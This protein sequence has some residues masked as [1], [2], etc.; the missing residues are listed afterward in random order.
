MIENTLRPIYQHYLVGPIAKRLLYGISPQPVTYLAGVTGI[1]VMPLLAFHFLG[2]ATF[3]LLLSGFLDTLDGTIARETDQVSTM[4]S[5]L[6]IMSDRIVEFAVILGLFAID[7][8]SRA[9]FSLLMLGSCYLCVTS[10]LVIGIF[11]PKS[12]AKGF[13]YS[14]GLIERTEAFIFFILMVWLP[15]Y[16]QY[17][18]MM[19]IVLVLLTS[20]LHIRKFIRTL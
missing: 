15:S 7:P 12:S 11:M 1:V 17:L 9:T 20:Y 3:F 4:G 5:I 8:T 16:F 18:A 19:F 14:P 2:L 6:D 13:Y 10:F